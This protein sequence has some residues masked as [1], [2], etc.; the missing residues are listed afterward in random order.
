MTRSLFALWCTRHHEAASPNI[1]VSP[2]GTPHLLKNSCA[3]PSPV[4][5]VNTLPLS[6]SV[7]LTNL[8][9]SYKQNCRGTS[10][11]HCNWLL[12]LGVMSSRFFYVAACVS[13]FHSLLRLNNIPLYAE[14]TFCLS[15]IYR[16]TLGLILP[17]LFWIMLLSTWAHKYPFDFLLSI[18]WGIYLEVESLDYMVIL[19]L[20]F[21]RNCHTVFVAAAPFYIPTSSAQKFQFLCILTNALKKNYNIHSNGCVNTFKI[22]F[23][24]NSPRDKVNTILLQIKKISHNLVCPFQV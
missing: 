4:P 8:R 7:G 24:L 1:F 22:F 3:A 23:Y 6:V 15:T 19:C 14:T 2:A 12:S 17:L 10:C 16:W 13:E 5:T 18:L 11:V 9:P 20:I 21:L